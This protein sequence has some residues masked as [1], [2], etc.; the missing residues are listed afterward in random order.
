MF[1]KEKNENWDFI[2]QR[3][4]IK[5]SNI[6]YSGTLLK[7]INK[8]SLLPWNKIVKPISLHHK[9]WRLISKFSWT[10]AILSLNSTLHLFNMIDFLIFA[11]K[12][13]A[14]FERILTL[15]LIQPSLYNLDTFLLTS[16]GFLKL[17]NSWQ[18]PKPIS[19]LSLMV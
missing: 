16:F 19:E 15:V 10:S 1:M 18:D 4:H 2:F 14:R 9:L 13:V 3:H 6:F 17:L 8:L 12:C 11:R 5:H 7:M